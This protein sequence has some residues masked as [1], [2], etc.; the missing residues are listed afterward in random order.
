MSILAFCHG[1]AAGHLLL[2]IIALMITYGSVSAITPHFVPDQ[3]LIQSPIIVVARWEKAPLRRTEDAGYSTEIVVERVV[4]GDLRPGT[5]TV[6]EVCWREN[7]EMEV[8]WPIDGLEGVRDVREPNLYFIEREASA[9]GGRPATRLRVQFVRGVQPLSSEPYFTALSSEDPTSAV[10]RLLDA[11]DPLMVLRALAYVNGG[12]FPWPYEWCGGAPTGHGPLTQHA[13]AVERLLDRREREVRGP[14]AVVFFQLSGKRCVPRARS[15]LGDEEE[16]IRATAVIA[17]ATHHDS[18]SAGSVC[19]TVKSIK[20][21]G[22][23]CEVIEALSS[24]GEE[25]IVPALVS[26]LRS[27]GCASWSNVGDLGIPALKA[28]AALHK[29]TGHWFPFEVDLSMAAWNQVTSLGDA[30]ARKRRLAELLPCEPEPLRAKLIDHRT[31]QITNR[32]QAPVAITTVPSQ[33]MGR[34]AGGS[35]QLDLER[36]PQG[37]KD[38]VVLNPG[39]S[40]EL[41][42]VLVAPLLPDNPATRRLA[43]TYEKFAK[44]ANAGRWVG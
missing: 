2:L 4:K 21:A 15:L 35:V 5:H 12:K 8:Y 18:E 40:T 20:N 10:A 6:Y 27:D 39:E 26:F 9:D 41:P 42:V 38:S 34:C 44:D 23:A 30:D 28:R 7:G 33:V 1:N 24:W 43:F 16:S 3:E 25:G 29:L 17:L 36:I 37:G 19:A 32:S 22:W 31:V 13:A 11:E 14:A